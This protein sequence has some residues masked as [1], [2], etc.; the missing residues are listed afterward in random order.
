MGGFFERD[1]E[2]ELHSSSNG[3]SD[4]VAVSFAGCFSDNGGTP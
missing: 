1:K 2:S 4:S 3:R